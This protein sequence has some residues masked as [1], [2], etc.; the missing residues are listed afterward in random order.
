MRRER[1]D[2]PDTGAHEAS[3]DSAPRHILFPYRPSRRGD[4]ALR[5]AAELAEEAGAPLTVLAPVVNQEKGRRCCGLQGQRWMELLRESAADDLDRARRVLG[6]DVRATFAWAEGEDFRDIVRRFAR[7]HRCDMTVMAP[8]I[9]GALA[10]RRPPSA[11]VRG[12]RVEA[13]PR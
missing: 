8:S 13:L 5:A 6:P 1:V 12:L 3:A 9:V 10:A 4:R 2:T 11:D 7:E